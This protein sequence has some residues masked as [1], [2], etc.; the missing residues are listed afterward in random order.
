MTPQGAD[1]READAVL[2]EVFYQRGSRELQDRFD[3]RRMADRLEDVIVHD[4]F[5][6]HDA[7]FVEARDMFFLATV[8]EHGHPNVSYKGGETGFVKVVDEMTL[9]FPSYDGNGMFLSLGNIVDA[10][11]VGMLFIDFEHRN[12]LRVNGEASVDFDDPMCSQWPEAQ[13]VVRVRPTEIFPNCPRYIHRMT[14]VETSAFVPRE[15]CATPVPAW[16]RNDWAADV[17][18]AGDP[19]LDPDAQVRGE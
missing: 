17:L 5:T 7:A 8:D 11:H 1:P 10:H 18:P 2:D 14:K 12:R 9:A 16:K 3:S 15:D 6:D 4:R 19:A 13:L